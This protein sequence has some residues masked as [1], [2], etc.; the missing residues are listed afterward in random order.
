MEW[1]IWIG[2]GVFNQNRFFWFGVFG[3][4][5]GQPLHRCSDVDVGSDCDSFA[6]LEFQCIDDA[7]GRFV[8]RTTQLLG[9]WEAGECKIS[10]AGFF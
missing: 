1:A 6:N 3:Q 9:E 10:L 5:C 7:L 2:R 4:L 8:G